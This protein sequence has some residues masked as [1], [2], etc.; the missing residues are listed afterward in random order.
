MLVVHKMSLMMFCDCVG[1]LRTIILGV[2]KRK[3]AK[4]WLTPNFWYYGLVNVSVCVESILERTWDQY[5]MDSKERAA[6]FY[7]HDF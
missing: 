7:E 5:N 6:T 4:E 1:C 3:H 2:H